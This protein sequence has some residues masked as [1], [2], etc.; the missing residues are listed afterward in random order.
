MANLVN[1]PG[2]AKDV[3]YSFGFIEDFI[4]GATT[5]P[6][7]WADTSADTGASWAIADG[8]RGIVTGVCGTTDNNE[9]AL[10]MDT[11]AFKFLAD[12][13]IYF[14]A[15]VQF[16]Q[17]NTNAINVWVGLMD[18]GGLADS[19][20]DNGGGPKSSYSGCGF[21]CVDG[22]LTW[23]VENSIGSTP[24]TTTLTAA[25]SLDKTLH[26][27]ASSSYQRLVI[28][29]LPTDATH[30]DFLFYI[31]DMLVAKHTDQTLTSATDMEVNF[32][33][34][35]G[36]TTDESLLVDYVCCFQKR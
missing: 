20:T 18:A 21:F 25:N 17:A 8:V 32:I 27:A 7:A 19:M 5:I 6:E 33:V 35:Q 28:E 24:V 4:N 16:S 22:A 1:M 10:H 34:K 2:W 29:C 36:S 26:N 13:P 9:A 11:E 3:R 31:D 23:N 14:E 15:Y 12:K 30:Q